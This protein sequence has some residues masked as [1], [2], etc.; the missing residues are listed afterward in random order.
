MRFRYQCV[1][2]G[3]IIVYFFSTSG[4]NSS[5]NNLLT[6]MQLDDILFKNIQ[7]IKIGGVET[8]EYYNLSIEEINILRESIRQGSELIELSS[9]EMPRPNIYEG[10]L[11]FILRWSDHHVSNMIF[12]SQKGYLNIY[13]DQVHRDK[14]DKF[15]SNPQ[16]YYEYIEKYLEGIYRIHVCESFLNYLR[17]NNLIDHKGHSGSP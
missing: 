15:Y 9:Q 14:M 12:E 3:C 16:L 7:S 2:I 4:C 11:I 10:T 17:D 13:K 1:I 6:P 5:K 8:E